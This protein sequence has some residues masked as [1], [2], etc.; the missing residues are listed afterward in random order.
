MTSILFNNQ[1]VF[2][3]LAPTPLV[4]L[5]V[6]PVR[7]DRKLTDKYIIKLNGT[8]T[9]SFCETFSQIKAKQEELVSRFNNSIG[10]FEI[11][12]DI[13][14]EEV[15][16]YTSCA[17]V[18]GINFEESRMNSV[19]PFTIDLECYEDDYLINSGVIEPI[20][21]ISFQ[22]SDDGSV[23]VDYEVSAKGIRDSS[24]L[25]L[26]RAI[27]YVQSL[28]GISNV[29]G[30]APA[31]IPASQHGF[32]LTN[33]SET[34]DRF[35]NSYSVKSNYTYDANNT[36]SGNASFLKYSVNVN[37]G[38]EDGFIQCSVNGSLSKYIKNDPNLLLF[39]FQDV[40][41]YSLASNYFNQYFSG[42]LNQ[43]PISY[44][45]SLDNFNGNLNF[46]YTYDNNPQ[47]LIIITPVIQINY[48]IFKPL[49]VNIDVDFKYRGNCL[50]DSEAGWNDL[51]NESLIYDYVGAVEDKILEYSSIS[52]FSFSGNINPIAISESTSTDKYNCNIKISK[53][54]GQQ[55]YSF[56]ED[57][58][59]FSFKIN[60]KPSIVK[61]TPSPT[62]SQ[63][64]WYI[65]NL[66]HRN[67][68]LYSINGNSR[69]KD[70]TSIQEGLELIKIEINQ[71]AGVIVQGENKIL[72]SATIRQSEE[73]PRIVDF[74]FSWSAMGS[75]FII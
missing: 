73:N 70:C 14:G 11:K 55:N 4:A 5:S 58:E 3:G 30:F 28:T 65:Q 13:S 45:V 52:P 41:P 54:Y 38:V 47:D 22:N 74:S 18:N 48:E 49:S 42:S 21:T 43:N 17:K 40:D 68:T 67:R 61:Y 63:N 60:I 12:T 69:I 8:L 66:G 71:L 75:Q 23:S 64:T 53:S 59:S 9:G 35:N 62:I 20:R 36:N 19:I 31:L 72:E 39:D 29:T 2:S 7:Y 51:V 1:Y 15:N 6:Q 56:S 46:S 34:F 33:L 16:F 37:S 24:E 57:L 10:P 26:N 27:S 50:C 44:E 32:L 25:G